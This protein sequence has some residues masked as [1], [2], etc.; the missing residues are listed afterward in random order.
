MQM[1]PKL[2]KGD[3][4]RVIAP[5]RSLANITQETRNIALK[6]F[7]ELGLWV[8]FAKNAEELDAFNSSS[9]ESRVED[10]HE[11]FTD[12][13]VKGILT[14]LGGW[15]SNQ[16]LRYIDFKKIAKNP[17]VFCGFSDISILNNAIYAKT[18]L[19]NYYGPH[20]SSF[21][22]ERGFGYTFEY[23]KKCFFDSKP[24]SVRPSDE[25]SDDEWFLD[26]KK[27]KEINNP[28]YAV[29]NEGSAEGTIIGGNLCTLNLLQGTEFMPSLK[30]SI[31]FI[32]DDHESKPIHFDRDLQ[33]LILQPGF[34]GVR[35]IV[36]GRF[37][38]ESE[39]TDELLKHIIRT[40][41]ELRDVPVV[42]GADFGHTTP[43]FT[44]PIGGKAEMVSSKKGVILKIVEH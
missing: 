32:E 4:I 8:S 20:F 15:N 17:K 25:W 6:R 26:Q 37:Q 5:A 30:N 11:A 40:K 44:F 1:P 2:K 27:R 12:R 28:G 22:M 10:L 42:S 23:F 31:L 16:L 14:T 18:G 41:K 43:M 36:I 24:F 35:G 29:I 3:E 13:N 39:M 7:D 38:R 19:V 34:D 21:G 9:V 33:S